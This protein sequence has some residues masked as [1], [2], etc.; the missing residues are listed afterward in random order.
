MAVRRL[1]RVRKV[2][3]G[4]TVYACRRRCPVLADGWLG[5]NGR[6]DWIPTGGAVFSGGSQGRRKRA[7]RRQQHFG[8]TSSADRRPAIRE[9]RGWRFSPYRLFRASLRGG[10]GRQRRSSRRVSCAGSGAAQRRPSSRRVTGAAQGEEEIDGGAGRGSGGA[11][12]SSGSF[13][14]G[15]GARSGSFFLSGVGVE[16]DEHLIIGRPWIVGL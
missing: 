1:R 4:R 7:R 2:G 10:V 13:F 6:R 3:A 14:S 16:Y 9:D 11:G 8:H 12:A 5:E 15:A